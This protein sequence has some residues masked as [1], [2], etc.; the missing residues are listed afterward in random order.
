LL[1]P[2]DFAGLPVCRSAGLPVALNKE[3]KLPIFLVGVEGLKK[4]FIGLPLKIMLEKY[5]R[6]YNPDFV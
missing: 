2:I 5:I 4:P 3:K 6:N 1:I